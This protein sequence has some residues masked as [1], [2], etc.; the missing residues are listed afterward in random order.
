MKQL[1]WLSFDLGIDGDYSNLYY[2]LDNKGAKDC[3]TNLAALDFIYEDN[4][5][6]EIEKD[7]RKTVRLRKTDRVYVIYGYYEEGV[8]KFRGKFIVGNRKPA[9]WKGFADEELDE[10]EDNEY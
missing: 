10:A 4:L 6:K 1:V 7:L 5:L 2:W 3:G 8:K 9:P